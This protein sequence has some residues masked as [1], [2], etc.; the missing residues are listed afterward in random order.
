MKK[1]KNKIKKLK[2]TQRIAILEGQVFNLENQGSL[3]TIS[4]KEIIS[5]NGEKF[6]L[7]ILKLPYHNM[8]N[9]V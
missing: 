7:Q 9:G 4:N 5:D 1:I 6:N 3:K 2:L 8:R